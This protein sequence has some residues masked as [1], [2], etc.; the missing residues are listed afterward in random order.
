MGAALDLTGQRFGMLVAIRPTVR[1]GLRAWVCDCECGVTTI[2]LT[3]QLRSG[4]TRSC[5]CRKR[6][7]LG[8]STVR[9]GLHGT[10][11]YATWKGIRNRC[12]NK[13][14]PNYRLWGGRGITMA[15]E[16]ADFASFIAY[17]NKYLGP[18][19]SPKHSLDRK[20]ND[21]NYEPGNLRW[22]TQAEQNANSR[23]WKK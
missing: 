23:R 16:W 2:V 22:A 9:H 19:P 3:G 20:D 21:G 1:K 10:Y 8:E 5:G 4:N 6:A 11:L 12:Y 17:I 15:P 18:R 13:R 7:V 14:G